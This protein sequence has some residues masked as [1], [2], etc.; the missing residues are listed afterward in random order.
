MTMRMNVLGN[1]RSAG[2]VRSD[3]RHDPKLR[4]EGDEGMVLCLLCSAGRD[5]HLISTHQTNGLL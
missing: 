3:L 4:E 1:G 5:S 2:E